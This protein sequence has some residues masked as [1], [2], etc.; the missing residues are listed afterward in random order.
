[1]QEDIIKEVAEFIENIRGD[2][3]S[4]I[5]PLYK[6]IG[7][8]EVFEKIVDKFFSKILADKRIK[9]FFDHSNTETLK[10]FFKHFILATLGGLNRYTG[11]SMKE[12]HSTLNLDDMHF[13]VFKDYFVECV[14]EE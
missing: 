7:G 4:I 12:A 11:K 9:Q 13:N 5:P 14:K 10:K 3:V 8:E 6:R 1:M 2:I